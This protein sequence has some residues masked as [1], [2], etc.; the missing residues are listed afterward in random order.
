MSPTL[1][2]DACAIEPIR[3]PGAIQP[4]GALIVLDPRDLR[5]LHASA[6]AP[7]VLGSD[8]LI[9]VDATSVL[10]A[11]LARDLVTWAA[12]AERIFRRGM[13]VAEQRWQVTA[14]RTNQG[15]ITEVEA[16]RPGEAET[17][18]EL[19]PRL[20]H[21]L[22]RLDATPDDSLA[23]CRDTVQQVR[24]L[25]GF[26]RVLIYRFD[27]DWNGTVLAEDGDG[28]LPSYLDLRFPASDIPAQARD[29][30]RLN[31]LRLIPDAN[32][33]PVGMEP[34]ISRIDG[35]PLDL[36]FATLR[37]VSPTHLEYMRNM[38]TAASMSVS[39]VIDG[40][41]WGLISCHHA[42]PRHLGPALRTACDSIG[43]FL[44]Q[45]LGARQRME[46]AA[47]RLD[48]K[49]TETGLLARLARSESFPAGLVD[50]A[51][52]WLSL[53]GATGA[54][55][56]TPDGVRTVGRSP[57][58]AEIYGLSE[59]LSQPD[60]PPVFATDRLPGYLA[61]AA[62]YSHIG[63]GLLSISISR[64]H[65]SYIMW[66]RPELVRTVTWA[67][68]PREPKD[69]DPVRLH[70]RHSFEHWQEL[71]RGQAQP[72]SRAEIDSAAE[73]RNAIL[74]F[75][76]RRAEERAELTDELQ[77]SNKE[78]ESFSYSVSH[79]LRAPFRH[80]V[81]YAELLAERAGH[82][83]ERASHYLESIREAAL[84]AGRLVDDLL[85]FSQ[86]NRTTLSTHLVDMEK[87]VDEA[88]R[89][90]EQEVRGR[91]IEW[92]I[93]SLPRALGDPSLLRQA[94]LNLLSN[95]VKYSRARDPA[96]VEVKGEEL[97]G[98]TV[99]TIRDNGIGFDMKYVGKLFGVFQRLHRIEEFEGT[100]IGLAL[101]KRIIDR[102]GG[103]IFAEGEPDEG[104][105][106]T[107]SLPKTTLGGDRG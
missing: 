89:S 8:G 12:G 51:E 57:G 90:L 10:E 77:R 19:Y 27:E 99:Y 24:Q 33:A 58:D 82:L 106:F 4:H 5:I 2:L 98:N 101:T 30:Y 65:R 103:R 29:L 92:R 18:D 11:R 20:Q 36:S 40:R 86:L 9:G 53:T 84:S 74:E 107:F 96:V 39:L 95:A 52:A 48:L 13:R 56:V 25:T 67:G 71:V 32:Y 42:E 26:N 35:L 94:L 38:G 47:K 54:A 102:H 93:G 14:H 16:E 87:L 100:G 88:R 55:V 66:F 7:A 59:W 97:D 60:T 50:N 91:N 37:S 3:T 63:C 64:L 21:F 44:A 104:A 45:H 83:D 70:P 28:T 61:P 62:A 78:L 41:L 49:R 81:G 105:T 15:I 72:W 23:A 31:R 76:L 85:N 75:V 69:R 1:D 46:E 22:E 43:Q 73:F 68:N 79:D 6:N 17:L 80:I 34:P